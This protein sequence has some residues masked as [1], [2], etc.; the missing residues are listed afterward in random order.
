MNRHPDLDS[1]DERLREWAHFYRDRRN[2]GHCRS[3]EHRFRATS[4][5]FAAEGWGDAESA[6]SARPARSYSVLRAG[7]TQDAIQ[8]LDRIY[9]WA[10]TY[11]YCYSHLPRF[12]VLRCMRKY[13]GRR[14]NWQAYLELLDIARFR[15]HTTISCTNLLTAQNF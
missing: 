7:Q 13:T 10:L 15:I 12:V 5:D 11:G 1:T 2:F 4:D 8:E 3:I 14:L 9:R 6:P